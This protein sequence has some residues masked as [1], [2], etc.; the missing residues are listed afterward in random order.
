LKRVFFDAN[1]LFTAA[2]NPGGKAAL[3][4]E[5]GTQGRL[6]LLTSDYA[7]AEARH[8]L[9]LKF[10]AS[11]AAFDG[12]LHHF[13]AVNPAL[14]NPCPIELPGKDQPIFVAAM[15]GNATH[16]LTGDL[17]DFG[18]H[19]NKPRRTLGIVVQ[20]VADFLNQPDLR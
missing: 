10:P 9:A 12:L 1:V 16:L 5:L 17:R 18:R 13:E 4:I 14:P 2:H 19:M 6:H 7:I 3:V 8:N 15:T 11:L 20:T